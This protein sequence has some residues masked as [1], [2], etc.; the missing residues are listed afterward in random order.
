M[1]RLADITIFCTAGMGN[2]QCTGLTGASRL[3]GITISC[4]G[5]V[6]THDAPEAGRRVESGFSCA[7]RGE[8]L[9]TLNT[10]GRL[11]HRHEQCRQDTEGRRTKKKD[12]RQKS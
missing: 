7:G 9:T 12:A 4:A 3:A 10:R 8:A 11:A 6:G 2:A 1:W 5:G